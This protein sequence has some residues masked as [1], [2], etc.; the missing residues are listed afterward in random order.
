VHEI[1]HPFVEANF[2]NC[3]PWFNE[4]LGSLYEQSGEE[5]GHIHGFTNW[6]LP[7]LQK[8]IKAHTVP[9]FKELM[10]MDETAFYNE[11]KGTNYG[12]SR[13]LCYYLQEKGL[14]TKFYKEFY[15]HRAED[16]T[17]YKTLQTILG[18]RNMDAFQKRWETFVLGLSEEFK[19]LAPAN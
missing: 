9:P 18:E 7:G 16:P 14:L 1:V 11:D 17:G 12:Q 8:A 2:P 15:A 10:A 5:D 4:G 19:L 3:P 6:R 13:Y